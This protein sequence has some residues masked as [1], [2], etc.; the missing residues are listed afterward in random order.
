M[1]PAAKTQAL[2]APNDG[3]TVRHESSERHSHPL[4]PV[5]GRRPHIW[6][7]MLSAR[8]HGGAR[9]L[10][11]FA[12][13]CVSHG[14]RV[15][16]LCPSGHF[17]SNYELDSRVTVRN[18]GIRSGWKIVDYTSFLFAV[19][20]ALPRDG[21]AVANFFVTYFPVRLAA[22]IRR[23]AYIYF[24]QDIECKYAGIGGWILNQVCKST[25]ADKHIVAANPYLGD[26]LAREF[27]RRCESIQVGPAEIFYRRPVTRPKEFDIIYFLRRESWK[28]LDRFRRFVAL[29]GRRVSILCI[30]QD[31]ALLSDMRREGMLACRKPADDEELID[32]IDSA[33]VLLYTSYEE[34][35]AL[36]PLEAMARGVPPIMYRCGGPD[37]YVRHGV[38]SLYV[39]DEAEAVETVLRVIET[40][41]IYQSLSA[42]GMATAA[43][44]RMEAGLE[45]LLASLVQAAAR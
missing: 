23:T 22:L 1:P 17:T 13:Y 33:R 7:P 9:V 8:W 31:D 14:H 2:A 20:F 11:Q 3:Q 28:G 19:P 37:I 41:S 15:T 25:Y 26:R 6:I 34:G 24:V 10:L 36:P 30:S 35:F 16:I 29:C 39:Q 27:G 38:N 40:R 43:Q 5:E 21:M 18:P 42:E 44:Y 32:C 45:R 12:N 4:D